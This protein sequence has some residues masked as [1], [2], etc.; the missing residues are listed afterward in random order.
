[1]SKVTKHTPPPTY[2]LELT[3]GEAF[4]L[5][6]LSCNG[7]AGHPDLLL[8]SSRVWT[9]FDEETIDKFSSWLGPYR[10]KVNHRSDLATEVRAYKQHIGEA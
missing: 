4:H 9:W 3:E 8:P 5:Y 10:R 2:T 6:A 7:D 1:M